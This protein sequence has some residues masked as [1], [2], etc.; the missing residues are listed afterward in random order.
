MADGQN[1]LVLEEPVEQAIFGC[2]VPFKETSLRSGLD[3]SL[4][5]EKMGLGQ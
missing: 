5:L 4:R 1:D 3:I 2:Y